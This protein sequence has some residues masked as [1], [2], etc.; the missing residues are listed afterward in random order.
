MSAQAKAGVAPAANAQGWLQR[1]REL[2]PLIDGAAKVHEIDCELA[3]EVVAAMDRAGIFAMMVPSELR[4]AEAHPR[5]LI[6]VI[7]ELS[8]WDGSAGW[9]AHAVMTGGSVAGAF[10]G[11]RAVEAIFPGGRFVHAAGQAAPTGRAVR[12]GEGYRISGR[13]S[14]GSGT[15]HAQYIV[16]GFV[17]HEGGEPVRG[18]GGQPVM[19]I[20][21]AP[22]E[23]VTFRGNW[24]VM[25]LRGTGSYDFTVNEQVLHEDFF[26]NPSAPVQRRGGTLYRMGFMALPCISHGAFAVGAT[27]RILDEWRRFART[28]VRADGKPAS[29]MATFHRDIAVHLADARAAEAYFRDT[30][31]SLFEA[32]GQGTITEDMRVDG[33]LSTSHAFVVAM[34]VAQAAY[35]ACTTTALRNGSPIQ[36][37]FRDICAGNAHFLTAEQSLIDAGAVV[38]EAEGAMLVF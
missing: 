33:R 31:D 14:F 23:T 24:D 36:R 18:P 11:D 34:R 26:H 37:A 1:T 16:G 12:E 5:D 21:L 8:Y 27:R 28:K 13:Y 38:A 10:L 7:S 2:G 30:F 35:A 9:Y 29:E 20:G 6:D 19:L 15:P 22:R 17:L 4:G 3:P 25:G 32:A